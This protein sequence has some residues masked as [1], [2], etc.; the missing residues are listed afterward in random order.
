M[1]R[2]QADHTK[3]IQRLALEHKIKILE[4][5]VEGRSLTTNLE[6]RVFELEKDNQNLRHKIEIMELKSEMRQVSWKTDQ[7]D[8]QN[9]NEGDFPRLYTTRQRIVESNKKATFFI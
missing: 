4:T 1:T 8:S 9:L 3:E 6:K 5:Q 2:L 7:G